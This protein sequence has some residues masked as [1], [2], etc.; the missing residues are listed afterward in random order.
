[1]FVVDLLYV[2][3]HIT[4]SERPFQTTVTHGGF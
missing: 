4:V 1:M 3:A 2:S